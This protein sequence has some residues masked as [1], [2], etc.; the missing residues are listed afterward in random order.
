MGPR[1]RAPG[2]AGVSFA[3]P[4]PHE[5]AE[6]LGAVLEV[7]YLLFNE[8]YGATGDGGD[9]T[10]SAGALLRPDLC[11]EAIRLADLLTE[12][13][14]TDRPEVHALLALFWLQ[15]ARF[16]AGATADGELVILRDQDR[17]LW[18][19]KAITRGL[20]HLERAATGSNESAYH[21]EAAI[22]G[23][24][25]TAPSYPATDWPLILSLYD[26]LLEL[27]PS[28]IV[29]LNRLVAL[30]EVAGP[31]AALAKLEALA[32]RA[33]GPGGRGADPLVNYHLRWAVEADL[34]LHAGDPGSAAAAFE[35]AL[36]CPCSAPER[37]FLETRLTDA[38]RQA[39]RAV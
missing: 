31:A 29:A 28:P 26:R 33:P 39:L 4:A 21:L 15:T 2:A 19:S 1:W 37:R 7:H 12:R 14:E 13:P 38:R 5:L 16:P 18:S 36:A 10:G 8:G 6:R 35:R 27:S 17:S 32:D 30:A 20:Q 24:H 25:A 11:R 34:H 3:L 9:G 22:A 23:A